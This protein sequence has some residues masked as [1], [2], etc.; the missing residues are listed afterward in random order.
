VLDT[1]GTE[2]GSV[3]PPPDVE[4]VLVVQGSDT[5]VDYVPEVVSV[6]LDVTIRSADGQEQTNF[7]DDIEICFSTEGFDGDDVCLG[8]YTDKGTWECEDY[9]MDSSTDA[10]GQ[11]QVCGG[12][13]H[14][15]NFA[16][17]L[18]N[19][20]GSSSRC[21]SSSTDYLLVYLSI[22]FVG[23]AICIVVFAVVLI[24]LRLRYSVRQTSKRLTLGSDHSSRNSK[25]DFV[26][27]SFEE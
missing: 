17:L 13:K 6:A 20:A 7:A 18:N 24:E 9:C 22:A 2:V 25:A 12:T 23:V 10:D 19:E 11:S 8:F 3:K 4:G 1:D 15:T 16:L 5:T 27:P 21:G 26:E 14:L